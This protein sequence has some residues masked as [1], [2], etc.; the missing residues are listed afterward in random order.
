MLQHM[1]LSYFM[2]PL[3]LLA[4]PEWLL[5]AADRQRPDLRGVPLVHQ[6]DRRGRDLQRRRDGDPHPRARERGR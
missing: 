1:M 6:A 3:L 2:P 5:R 4:T